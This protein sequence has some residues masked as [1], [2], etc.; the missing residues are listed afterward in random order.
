MLPANRN[1]ITLTKEIMEKVS[2]IPTD[3]EIIN[4]LLRKI[5]IQIESE[6]SKMNKSILNVKEI[7]Y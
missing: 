7:I 3:E 1:R 5:T 4:R 2:E 6:T